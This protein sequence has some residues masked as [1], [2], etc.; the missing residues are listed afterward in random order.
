M[1]SDAENVA[2]ALAQINRAWLAGQP[3]EME[4]LIHPNI[5]LV[6]PGFAGRS[7]GR[8]AMLAGFESFCG[9]A[10]TLLFNESGHKVDVVGDTAVA[11]YLFDMV[12]EQNGTRTHSTGRDIWVLQRTGQQWQAVW[13]T[14]IDV[15]DEPA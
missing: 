7:E 14:M 8:P 2:A 4:P 11:S 9:T 10:K 6:Y 12:F 15:R 5:V 3:R 1:S 13:R